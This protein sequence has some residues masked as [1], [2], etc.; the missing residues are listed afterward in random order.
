MNPTLALEAYAV[1]SR[2]YDECRCP[3]CEGETDLIECPVFDALIQA[4]RDVI[5]SLTAEIQQ[6]IKAVSPGSNKAR[7]LREA[8]MHPDCISPAIW[9]SGWYAGFDAC[10]KLVLETK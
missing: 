8:A 7:K 10:K 1:A 3:R 2:D 4:E 5:D 6:Q 9:K